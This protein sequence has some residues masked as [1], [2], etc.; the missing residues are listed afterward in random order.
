MVDGLSDR[1][2]TEGGTPDEWA[3]LITALGVLGDAERAQVIY[4][5]AKGV[6]SS[7]PNALSLILGAGANAGVN[8]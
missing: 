7:D 2:A 4:D 1:L 6:F 8:R 5:E 3:R